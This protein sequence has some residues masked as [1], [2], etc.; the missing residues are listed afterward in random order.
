MPPR[1]Y[2][3]RRAGFLEYLRGAA[4]HSFA[5]IS[6]F[7]EFE[8]HG[9]GYV[10]ESVRQ[11]VRT[12]KPGGLLIVEACDPANLIESTERFW[13][14]PANRRLLPSATLESLLHYCG[15]DILSRRSLSTPG[16]GQLPWIELE[17]VQKLNHYFHGPSGYL[18]IARSRPP[19]TAADR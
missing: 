17:L 6:A 2:R 14:D 1:R 15:F 16:E 7:H 18:L 12:L 9:F 11:A 10:F 3:R 4:D 8:R 5:V 13:Q 19:S